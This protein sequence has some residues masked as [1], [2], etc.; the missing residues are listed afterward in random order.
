MS[1]DDA[2][3][4]KIDFWLPES[5]P[6]LST[7]GAPKSRDQRRRQNFRVG[8]DLL[9]DQIKTVL[10][11]ANSARRSG[12]DNKL[13]T[14]LLNSFASRSSAASAKGSVD[15]NDFASQQSFAGWRRA[16]PQCCKLALPTRSATLT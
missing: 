5:M 14:S 6:S 7:E 1:L 13:V 12:L 11:D 15:S 16:R 10:N 8:V 9:C 2:L 3:S 4:D